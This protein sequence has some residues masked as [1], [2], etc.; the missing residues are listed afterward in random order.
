MGGFALSLEPRSPALAL[1]IAA[2]AAIVGVIA[3]V[4]PEFAIAAS[5]AIAFLII[6]AVDLTLGLACFAALTFLE[7]AAVGGP[8]LSFAKVAGVALALSWLA[9][10]AT[11]RADSGNFV[12]SHPLA[13]TIGLFFLGWVA[14]SATWAEVPSKSLVLMI[15]FGL[16]AVLFLIVYSAVRTRDDAATVVTGFVAGV[17]LAATLGILKPPEVE[18]AGRIS[19]T[20]GD[21]NELALLLIAGLMFSLVFSWLPG[22]RPLLR[23]LAVVA[24]ALSTVALF[25]TVSRGGLI[26]L[27][28]VLLLSIVITGRWRPHAAAAAVAIA[29]AS[30]GYFATI[31][32]DTATDRLELLTEGQSRTNE[33]R[34][35][36]WEIGWRMFEENPA[37]GVGGGQFQ[38]ASIHYLLEPGSIARTDQVV[39]YPAAAHNTYLGVLA[40]LGIV[41][42]IGFAAIIGFSL[43]CAGRAIRLARRIGDQQIE[44]LAVGTTLALV[45]ML[46]GSF[47]LSN[48][49][50]KQ[51][52]LLMALTP[53]LLGVAQRQAAALS[54]V[55]ATPS[56]G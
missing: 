5:L 28:V 24:A 49:Y 38:T 53:A 23:M 31:A 18:A 4:R 11:R 40:E 26:A 3:G 20:I 39:D 44:A 1:L 52:W 33:G 55:R 13:A 27:A 42:G 46:V 45:A 47:F 25:L 35:S 15:S 2:P 48:E 7:Q 10:V 37:R 8:A 51:L 36:I 22:R 6:V 56:A 32:P 17:V 21:P 34:A 30:V 19:S 14:L 41:G 54:E 12:S 29:V 43:W 16:N 9:T 50:S